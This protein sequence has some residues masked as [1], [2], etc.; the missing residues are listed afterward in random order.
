MHAGACTIVIGNNVLGVLWPCWFPCASTTVCRLGSPLHGTPWP[1]IQYGHGN[2]SPLPS[3]LGV[4]AVSFQEHLSFQA[5]IVYY[6][7]VSRTFHLPSGILFTFRSRYVIRYRSWVVF[8]LA[9]WYLAFSGAQTGAS[10]SGTSLSW[11]FCLRLRGYH[12]L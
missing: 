6:M 11:L 12:P 9:S 1:V 4:T 3:Y 5:A 8:R 10:Y 7:V 2:F